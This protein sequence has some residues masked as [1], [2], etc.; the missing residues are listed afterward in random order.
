MLAGVGWGGR[1]LGRARRLRSAQPCPR[2]PARLGADAQDL[3]PSHS[4]LF[5]AISN[6]GFFSNQTP[7]R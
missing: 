4:S 3:P 2:Q 1:V 7:W 6:V 5:S